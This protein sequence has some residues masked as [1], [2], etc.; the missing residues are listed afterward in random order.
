MPVGNIS[1][2]ERVRRLKKMEDLT[3]ENPEISDQKIAEEMGMSLMA[4][5]RNK[6]YLQELK[7]ADITAQDAAEKRSEIWVAISEL[8]EEAKAAYDLHKTPFHCPKCK[9]TGS[10]TKK[11]YNKKTQESTE[12]PEICDACKGLG[13]IHQT[14]TIEKFL[15]LIAE[16]LDRKMRLYGL[17][18]TQSL[19]VNQQFNTNLTYEADKVPAKVKESIKDAIV[20]AHEKRRR[21]EYEQEMA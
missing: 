11:T 4:V 9:G 15:R 17:D 1:D 14:G 16:L 3:K 5:K 21:L 2:Q 19:T 10:Y 18:K 20:G 6:I 8:E 7:K 13:Q 12:E